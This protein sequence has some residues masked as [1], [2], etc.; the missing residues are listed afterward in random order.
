L[1][2]RFD[3]CLSVND[4]FEATG[5]I[6][7]QEIHGGLYAIAT[8]RGPYEKLEETYRQFYR[9]WVPTNGRELRSDPCLEVYQNDSATTKPEDLVTDIYV[10]L[11]D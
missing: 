7:V 3:A 2:W 9:D 8:H 11:A 5:E 4:H 1:I 10:P 6:G